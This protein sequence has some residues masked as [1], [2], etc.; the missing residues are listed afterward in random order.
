MTLLRAHRAIDDV[1][2]RHLEHILRFASVEPACF[3]RT[4]LPGHITGS[5]FIYDPAT[6]S[7]LLHHHRKLDRWLQMGGH[8]DGE[9]DAAATAFREAREESGLNRLRLAE[10]VQVLDVDVHLIPARKDEPA[11][12]HLDVRF[13]VLGDSTEPL[14]R[15]DVESKDLRWFPLEEAARQMGEPGALRVVKKIRASFRR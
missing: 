11:H 2:Q 10:P 15:D 1:E 7:L 9:Q 8:D 14:S 6:D 13:L 3:H 4:T 5:A 12:D